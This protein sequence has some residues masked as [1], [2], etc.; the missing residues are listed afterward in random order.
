[1]QSIRSCLFASICALMMLVAANPSNAQE[2]AGDWQGLLREAAA[3]A[4]AGDLHDAVELAEEAMNLVKAEA[5]VPGPEVAAGWMQ[6]GDWYVKKGEQYQA[7]RVFLRALR[8]YEHETT[9]DHLAIAE[10]LGRLARTYRRTEAPR[11]AE[12]ALKR[13]VE[14]LKLYYGP[15]HP[16]VADAIIQLAQGYFF[17]RLYAKAEANYQAALVMHQTTL[18]AEH[19]SVARSL[20]GMAAVAA[21]YNK[22]NE[23]A[24]FAEKARVVLQ[25]SVGAED[26]RMAKTL[27][28]LGSYYCALGEYAAAE[29]LLVQSISTMQHLPGRSEWALTRTAD[30]YSE[31][32]RAQGGPPA[33]QFMWDVG[34]PIGNGRCKVLTLLY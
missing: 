31:L 25:H 21:H 2:S 5:V 26:D 30:I 27:A 1:M 3:E 10:V 17:S 11:R 23:A 19:P 12:M 24:T 13:R 8:V 7:E 33:N 28:S 14:A 15:E 34:H 20:M 32:R 22:L 16:V 18:G 29:P 9:P 4:E 6:L